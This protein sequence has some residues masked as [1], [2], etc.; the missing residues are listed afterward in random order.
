MT[1]P[2]F[3]DTNILV[4]ARDASEGEK[5]SRALAWLEALWKIRRGR[6]SVQVLSE[7]Y[8]TVTRELK[9]GL[10]LEG[11]WEDVQALFAWKP[12]PLDQRV[13]EC[14]RR[15]EETCNLSWWDALIVG[16]AHTSGCR[17]LL[18]EDFTDGV[19]Y[20]GLT[21]VNPFRF[22]PSEVLDRR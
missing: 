17:W 6:L 11:A 10:P 12:I 22:A 2:V 5:Q 21:V 14:A 16:A 9:P 4:Y 1:G 18:S 13:L 20:E 15:I 19:R 3:V 8:V 7:F